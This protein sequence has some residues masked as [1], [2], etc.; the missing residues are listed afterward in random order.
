MWNA[1]IQRLVQIDMTSLYSN[2]IGMFDQ[3]AEVVEA[4]RTHNRRPHRRLDLG[5]LAPLCLFSGEE[6]L[7]TTYVAAVSSFPDQLP[8]EI[9][10][11]R[12]FSDHVQ[13]LKQVAETQASIA[14][15]EKYRIEP[16]PSQD[17]KVAIHPP[18]TDTPQAKA[19]ADRME[20]MNR[21]SGAYLLVTDLLETG[22]VK[23]GRPS[24]ADALLTA[25][26][27]WR[28]RKGSNRHIEMQD[29]TSVGM[30]AI[31]LRE[32]NEFDDDDIG[33]AFRVVKATLKE[34][35]PDDDMVPGTILPWHPLPMASAALAG[36][37]LSS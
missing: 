20:Q 22:E 28:E 27:L 9:E 16:V 34:P 32:R 11:E 24:R 30:A 23:E 5:S 29:G 25:K 33:W 15:A 14:Q 1:D 12:S 36:I 31:V 21:E 3:V 26:T 2:E 10:E 19:A 13:E 35:W 8:F 6:S 7:K 17:G 4:L 18:A 37:A